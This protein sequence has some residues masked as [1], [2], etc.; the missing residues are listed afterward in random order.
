MPVKSKRNTFRLQRLLRRMDAGNRGW[1]VEIVARRAG[2]SFGRY[3]Q[4]ETGRTAP[5]PVELD[6]LAALFGVEKSELVPEV[7]SAA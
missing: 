3:Q 1:T 2:I 7:V 5:T 4:I 6:K